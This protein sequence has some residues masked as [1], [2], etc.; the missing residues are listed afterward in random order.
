MQTTHKID[1]EKLDKK[2]D[3]ISDLL[4]NLG[5]KEDFRR[6]IQEWR[7]PGWTTP[8]E[9]L[10]VSAALDNFTY[11]AKGLVNMKNDLMEGTRAIGR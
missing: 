1:I 4:A 7:R 9:F 3:I 2:V 5:D 11:S 10:L 8:A 6:L